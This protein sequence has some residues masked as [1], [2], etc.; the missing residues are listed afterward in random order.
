MPEEA[1]KKEERKSKEITATI[2]GL[3]LVAASLALVFL[4]V[5]QQWVMFILVA[6]GLGIVFP[7]RLAD[8]AKAISNLSPLKK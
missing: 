6:L 8:A 2:A 5:I 1:K 7:S 3:V 4:G